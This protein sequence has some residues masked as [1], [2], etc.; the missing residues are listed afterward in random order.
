LTTGAEVETTSIVDMTNTN[1]EP[2]GALGPARSTAAS[3]C[4]SSRLAKA[5]TASPWCGP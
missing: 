3:R 2:V 1:D 5:T 4:G